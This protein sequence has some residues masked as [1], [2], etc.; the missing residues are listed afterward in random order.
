MWQKHESF[1]Q[2]LVEH[3]DDFL[4]ANQETK[5]VPAVKLP[6]VRTIPVTRIVLPMSKVAHAIHN[7][8]LSNGPKSWDEPNGAKIFV[9]LQAESV[10]IELTAFDMAVYTAVASLYHCENDAFSTA[11]VCRTL[12]FNPKMSKISANLLAAVEN[13]IH[14]MAEIEITIRKYAS[15]WLENEYKGFLLEVE[16]FYGRTDNGSVQLFWKCTQPPILYQYSLDVRQYWSCSVEDVQTGPALNNHIHAIAVRYCLLRRL[17]MM[18]RQAHLRRKGA[19]R[20]AYATFC[21][22]VGVSEQCASAMKRLRREVKI[23]LECWKTTGLIE[24]YS[25]QK[26]HNKIIGV[27]IQ[28]P[29]CPAHSK[30]PRKK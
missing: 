29:A 1:Y 10:P 22:E 19:N 4:Y 27:E 23:C 15:D 21:K 17:A 25:A 14:K 20:I 9:E 24:G 16:P 28:M 18:Q 12:C 26:R 3:E 6:F 7:G 5:P 11:A 13:S 30:A 8:K 2:K